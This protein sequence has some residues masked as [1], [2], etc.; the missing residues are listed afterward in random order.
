[1]SVC[2]TTPPPP[3]LPR[4]LAHSRNWP[5]A[6]EE[7]RQHR[8]SL[9]HDAQGGEEGGRGDRDFQ[10]GRDGRRLGSGLRRQGGQGF[11]WENTR[12]ESGQVPSGAFGIISVRR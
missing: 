4:S 8:L 6:G 9:R 2:S 7:G 3:A 1:M 11:D 12:A 5:E 10:S